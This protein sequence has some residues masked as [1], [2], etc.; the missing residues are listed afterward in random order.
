METIKNKFQSEKFRK[1]IYV[2]GS[3]IVA[4][5][6]FQAGVFVG[7]SKA[8]FSNRL[9]DNYR[10]TFGERPF[11]M[12]RDS[13]YPVAHGAVG[14]II[15]INLPTLVI[16]GSDNIEKIIILNN[17]TLIREYREALNPTDLKVNDEI[18]VIG[19]PD[20][21]SQI[22]AKLIRLMPGEMMSGQNPVLLNNAT[23]TANQ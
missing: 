18:V 10:K 20:N 19:S 4:L 8:S 14:K 23:G 12:M 7:A 15:K 3:V 2:V 17:D 11:G 6:I 5:V 9:G 21:S 1:I 13:E 16:I 22:E